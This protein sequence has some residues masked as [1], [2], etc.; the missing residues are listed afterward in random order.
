MCSLSVTFGTYCI[1][2]KKKM[3]TPDSDSLFVLWGIV[4]CFQSLIYENT[5]FLY[6]CKVILI[7]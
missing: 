1:Y 5:S 2:K 6:D 3:T 7:I 4:N